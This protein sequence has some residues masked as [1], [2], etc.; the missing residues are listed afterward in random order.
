MQPGLLA[1]A[2]VRNLV[3]KMAQNS[4]FKSMTIWECLI[5]R[6][7]NVFYALYV[8]SVY[9]VTLY[10]TLG[11]FVLKNERFFNILNYRT[12]ITAPYT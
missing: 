1:L 5:L 10:L 3:P 2:Q 9:P 11:Y 4:G 7:V 6:T 12:N 8:K